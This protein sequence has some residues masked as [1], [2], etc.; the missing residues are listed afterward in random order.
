MSALQK[1][2]PLESNEIASA[3]KPASNNAVDPY[4]ALSLG[5]LIQG[6]KDLYSDRPLEQLSAYLWLVNDGPVYLDFCGYGHYD[7][8]DPIVNGDIQSRLRSINPRLRR[9]NNDG[10]R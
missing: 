5:M 8:L 1:T 2:R 3:P 7:P 6:F 10:K 9:S 4:R